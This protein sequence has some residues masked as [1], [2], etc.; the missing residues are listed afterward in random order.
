MYS[1]MPV[2]V[3]GISYGDHSKGSSIN[4]LLLETDSDCDVDFYMFVYRL[5][6]CVSDM[7]FF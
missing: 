5:Y 1:M 2:Y 6:C 7:G 4:S 3:G